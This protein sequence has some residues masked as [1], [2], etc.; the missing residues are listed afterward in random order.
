MGAPPDAAGQL[1]AGTWR[2]NGNGFVGDLVIRVAANGKV[3]GTV[4]NHL[5]AGAGIRCANLAK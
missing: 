5:I 4:Y 2:L 1:V 3:D